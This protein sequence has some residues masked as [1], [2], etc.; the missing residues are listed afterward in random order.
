MIV[1]QKCFD[2]SIRNNLITYDDIRN[3]DDY[4][5]GCLL[6]YIYFKNYYKLITID[7]SNQQVLHADQKAIKN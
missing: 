3:I 5:T 2:Q 7:L 4:A 1:G 6:D